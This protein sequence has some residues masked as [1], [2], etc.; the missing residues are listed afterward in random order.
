MPVSVYRV[1]LSASFSISAIL[2]AEAIKLEN[3]SF[4][5][6]LMQNRYGFNVKEFP[7]CSIW[8]IGKKA[9]NENIS[10]PSMI[11]IHHIT[12]L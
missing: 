1:L 10:V 8:I 6:T 3:L 12:T 5:H 4:F 7:F 9:D 2:K 11:N